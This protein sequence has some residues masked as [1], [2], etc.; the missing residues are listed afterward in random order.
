M[1]S[2]KVLFTRKYRYLREI[3][4]GEYCFNKLVLNKK[5]VSAQ[6][7]R[8]QLV[9]INWINGES[10]WRFLGLKHVWKRL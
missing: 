2:E 7:V 9:G 5:Y 10:D 8:V 3:I 6:Y 4:I 1:K